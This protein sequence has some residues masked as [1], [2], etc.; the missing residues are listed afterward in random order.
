MFPFPKSTVPNRD[1]R[2]PYTFVDYMD[3]FE[4][5]WLDEED[6]VIHS[7]PET[8]MVSGTPIIPLRITMY[9]WKDVRCVGRHIRIS[10]CLLVCR[11]FINICTEKNFKGRPYMHY[12]TF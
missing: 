11:Q 3:I 7:T 5:E 12:F 4:L 10:V 6:V 2:L 9:T 8:A 1:H